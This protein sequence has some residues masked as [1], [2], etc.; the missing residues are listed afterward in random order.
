M[1]KP[2]MGL[3][4]KVVGGL[5]AFSETASNAFTVTISSEIS[6]FAETLSGVL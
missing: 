1:E 6:F 3:I 4:R 5:G 2:L